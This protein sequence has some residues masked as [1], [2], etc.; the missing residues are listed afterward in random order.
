VIV[1]LVKSGDAWMVPDGTKLTAEQYKAY[2]AGE[3]YV[4]AH[5]A[6]NKGG[7]VRGQLLPPK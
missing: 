4:N 2:K 3:L 5:S 7:E 6:E 1:P